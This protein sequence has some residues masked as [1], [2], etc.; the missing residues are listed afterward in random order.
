MTSLKLLKNLKWG[1]VSLNQ[2]CEYQTN[3]I[4]YSD[5]IPENYISTENMLQNCEGIIKFNGTPE[6]DNVIEYKKGDILVSNIRPYLQ[7]IWIADCDG[8]CNPDVLVIRVKDK[9]RFAPMYVYYTLRRQAFFD[10]MMQ[11]KSGVKMPRGNK[12]NNLRFDIPNIQYSEQQQI[13][14]QVE[15]MET[16]IDSAIGVASTC[17]DRK[18]E[19]LNKYLFC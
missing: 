8:G 2:I 16:V 14:K 10:H 5:I 9:T 18:R 4:A 15:E 7:K 13:L 19:V 3:R 6:V 12:V 1:V 17:E 11:D